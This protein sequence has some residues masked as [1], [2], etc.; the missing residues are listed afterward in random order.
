PGILVIEAAPLG[1]FVP[2]HEIARVPVLAV[3]PGGRRRVP[4]SVA[5][6]LLPT[7]RGPVE[8][9]EGMPFSWDLELLLSAD[10]V[11]NLDGWFGAAHGGGVEAHGALDLKMAGGRRAA[12]AVSLPRAE[13][14][15][16]F[17]ITGTDAGWTA[18]VVHFGGGVAKFVVGAPVARSRTA[19]TLLV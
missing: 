4:V 13:M 8:W 10:W 17:A 2:G 14:G 12:M 18:E 5:R 11:G 9:P 3:D 1:A 6:A 16:D 15:F 19:I 7:T